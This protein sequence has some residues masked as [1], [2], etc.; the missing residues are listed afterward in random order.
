MADY[1]IDIVTGDMPY[2]D[3]CEQ[4]HIVLIG[5]KGQSEE[6]ELRKSYHDGFAQGQTDSFRL[7]DIPDLGKLTQVQIKLIPFDLNTPYVKAWYL[8]LVRVTHAEKDNTTFTWTCKCC[9]WLGTEEGQQLS[10]ILPVSTYRAN[11]QHRRLSS[12][13]INI[14]TKDKNKQISYNRHIFP[15]AAKHKEM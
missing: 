1:T 4:V 12:K 7:Q 3:T 8:N 15:L 11:R 5:T 14:A 10:Y 13:T 2:A 9:R 6:L